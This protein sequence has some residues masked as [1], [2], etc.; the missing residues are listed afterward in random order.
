[1]DFGRAML[2]VVLRPELVLTSLAGALCLAAAAWLVLLNPNHRAHRALALVLLLRGVFTL[3]ALF[4]PSIGLGDALRRVRLYAEIAFPF[5]VLYLV[6]VTRF[7]PIRFETRPPPVRHPVLPILLLLVP[8]ALCAAY[9]LDHRLLTQPHPV[10]GT[11]PG[12]LYFVAPVTRFV[13]ALGACMI[14]LDATRARNASGQKSLLLLSVGL[15]GTLIFEAGFYSGLAIRGRIRSPESFAAPPYGDFVAAELAIN[16]GT[17]LLVALVGLTT[18]VRART[19]STRSLPRAFL[20][21]WGVALASALLTYAAP[22]DAIALAARVLR[23]VWQLLLPVL[24]AYAIMRLRLFEADLS[25][26]WLLNKGILG[27]LFVAFFFM[28]VETAQNYFGDRF[29]LALGGV[30]TGMLFLALHPLERLSRRFSEAALPHAKPVRDMT[31][32]ERLDIYQEQAAVAWGDGELKRKERLLLDRLALRL[33]LPPED[34]ARLEEAV[35]RH[36]VGS[37]LTSTPKRDRG[38]AHPTR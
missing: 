27:S 26:R 15:A 1:M 13:A 34:C 30:L 6:Y 29:G 14:F 3:P 18:F 16:L 28:T 24:T 17:L 25:M 32:R 2:D 7:R 33:G 8:L 20:L 22:A 31:H 12:P 5:A 23:G 21:V 37:A 38:S 19:P 9:L 4:D 11:A 10:Y 35:Y 36:Q